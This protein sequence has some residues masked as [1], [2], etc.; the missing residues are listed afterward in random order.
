MPGLALRTEVCVDDAEVHAATP[1]EAASPATLDQFLAQVQGRG[2]R[3]A[4]LALG[5]REAA[6]D[7]VQDAMTALISRYRDRPAE[8]WEPLF[9]RILQ[10]RIRDVYRRR[11]VRQRVM[12]VLGLGDEPQEDPMLTLPDTFTPEPDRSLE[13]GRF[14][15]DLE[16]A[17]RQLPLR[18]QQAFLLRHWEGLDTAA[19]AAALG[20]SEGSVKTHLHRAL[21]TL[22]QH[23]EAYR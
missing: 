15:V 2:V 3:M 7:V 6:L 20:V 1:A 12:A 4:A 16:S 21:Q 5:D 22:R 11:R 13:D 14:A 10:T 18:Q 17:L 9:W 23:L 8:A 19:T